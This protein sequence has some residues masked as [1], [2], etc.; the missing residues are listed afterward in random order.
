MKSDFKRQLWMSFGLIFGAVAVASAAIYFLSNDLTA[1]AEKIIADKNLIARQA[2]FV[3][4]LASLKS[5]APV[6]IQYTAAINKLLP[7]HD[8]LI[9]FP[10]W[11]VNLG[12]THNVSIASA[13]QGGDVPPTDEAPGTDGFSM[14]VTGNSTDII[15]FLSDIESQAPAFLLSLDSFDFA[16]TGSAYRLST[17]GKLFSQ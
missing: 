17:Q 3:G 6:A 7:V 2:A 1:Q 9:G 13:F 4:V 11:L 5:D 16:N 14:G 12:Q 15:A 8:E 10:Q